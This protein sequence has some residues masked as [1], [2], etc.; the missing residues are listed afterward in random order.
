M[1]CVHIYDLKN[2][3]YSDYIKV[4]IMPYGIELDS[5]KGRL[6]V[7]SIGRNTVDIIDICKKTVIQRIPAGK[8]P[9]S[10]IKNPYI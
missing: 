4:N 6:F 1:G 2:N 5:K 9:T 10:I 8:E 7:T 3:K